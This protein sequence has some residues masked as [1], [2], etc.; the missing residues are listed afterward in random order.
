MSEITSTNSQARGSH[1]ASAQQAAK[2]H[3]LRRVQTLKDGIT[4]AAVVGFMVLARVFAGQQAGTA[5]AAGVTG[6]VAPTSQNQSSG[7][8]SDDQS[9]QSNGFFSQ[10]Q[11]GSGIGPGS[12]AQ[13]PVAGTG[14]S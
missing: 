4:V 13:P 3:A 7:P 1:S 8:S 5:T 11:G 14:A 2:A 9:T 6:Q 10:T 12:A